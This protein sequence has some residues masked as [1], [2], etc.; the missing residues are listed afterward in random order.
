MLATGKLSPDAIPGK[1]ASRDCMLGMEFSGR[2]RCGRRVMGLVPAEGLATSVLLS[3]DFLWDVPSSWTLEEAASVPVVY[4]T[5]Y[6]SLVVRGRIQRGETVLIH[7]GSGGVGQAAISIA[8]SLGCRVFTTVGSA[9]KRA[10]LQAR[11]P[12]L[13]DTSFANSRDTSFEQ[14]VLLHTGGKGV[15]LVLNSLAEEKLQASVRCLAQHGRFLEIGKFD[16]SNNHPLGMAIFLKNVTFH[17][18]LLDALFEEAN[19]SWRE[20]AALLKAGIR[21][22]VVK[23]LSAQC[24][25]RPRWKMPSATWLRGNTL[26]KSLSRYGRRSLRLCCQGLSPP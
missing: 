9:E 16:L 23:P 6:Y 8:L 15:D 18:I 11:F 2:D 21:D 24:F 22:G 19:D 10:Y 1:W 20:V 7:S 3:S 25:P 17:G 26:A 13:D 14:H 5:A 4:T 12:Q